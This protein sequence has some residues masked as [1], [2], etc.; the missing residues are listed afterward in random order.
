MQGFFVACMQTRSERARP[1]RL[2]VPGPKL[3][4]QTDTCARF[5]K[6]CRGCS[7]E[8][9]MVSFLQAHPSQSNLDRHLAPR[10]QGPPLPDAFESVLVRS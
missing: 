2:A 5:R 8:F 9:V 6:S 4:K 10:P 1:R 3:A 7:T